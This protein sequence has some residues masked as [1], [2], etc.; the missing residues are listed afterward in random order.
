MVLTA[1]QPKYNLLLVLPLNHWKPVICYFPQHSPTTS[2][3]ETAASIVGLLAVGV[4]IGLALDQFVSS[5]VDAPVI[6]RTVCDEVRD[7]RFALSKLQPYVDGTVAINLLGA[8]ATDVDHLSLTLAS[9]LATFSRLEKIVDRLKLRERMDAVDR[10]RWIWSEAAI[11]QLVQ[12]LQHHKST[13]TLL[14]TIWIR[15]VPAT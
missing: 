8:S 7:F 5:C 2:Q 13:L 3:M 10:L 9:C 4:K 1:N 14:L 15:Y 6:A 12:R 11:A